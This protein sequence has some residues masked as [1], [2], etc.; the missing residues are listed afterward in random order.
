MATFFGSIFGDSITPDDVSVFVERTPL[1]ST[2]T[3]AND[4]LLGNGGNDTLNGGGGNDF[5]SGDADNDTISDSLGDNELT[6]GAGNDTLSAGTG[7]DTLFGNA[8]DD[9][10]SDTGGA[11]LLNGGSGA[12]TLF[13]TSGADTLLGGDGNDLLTDTG[14]LN[15]LR[16][17]AGN[18]TLNGGI[19][20]DVLDGG[21]GDDLMRGDDGSDFYEVD[22]AADQCVEFFADALA[23]RDTVQAG[24][25]YTLGFG[26]E[27]LFLTDK[28][29]D[30]SSGTGNDLDNFIRG[31]DLRN[32]LSG[33]D[34]NDSLVGSNGDDTLFG[35]AGDD[36]LLGGLGADVLIGEAG[37][38]SMSGADGPDQYFVDSAA[39]LSLE[40]ADTAAAGDDIVWSTAASYVIGFG[41]ERLFLT[42]GPNGVAGD[43]AGTGNEKNNVMRGNAGRNALNGAAGNDS[44][45]GGSGDDTLDGG[46][47]DDTLRGEAGIDILR[48]GAGND[49][50]DGGEGGDGFDLN[51][52]TSLIGLTVLGGAGDDGA[53]FASGDVTLDT[54]A[55]FVDVERIDVFFTRVLGTAGNDRLDFSTIITISFGFGG[56][57]LVADGGGGDDFIAGSAVIGAADTLT[58]GDGDDWLSGWLG[59]DSLLGGLGRDTLDGGTGAGEFDQLEGGPGDDLYIM[60]DALEVVREFANGG[61]DRVAS[62]INYTLV[63]HLEELELAALGFAT[64][65]AGNAQDNLLIGNGLNNRLE[66][67]GG[68]DRL[69]GLDGAD[70]LFGFA[71][72]DTLVG[73]GASDTLSG[74]G[75]NDRMEGGAGTDTVSYGGVT[76][77][78]VASLS[79][80]G[81][82]NTLGAGIDEFIEI[83]NLSG[84]N[85]NDTLAGD[86]GG[87][88]LSGSAGVDRLTGLGGVDTLVGGTGTDLFIFQATTESRAGAADLILGDASAAAFEGAGAA[89]GDVIVL[90]GVDADTTLAGFQSFVFGAS[91]GLGRVWATN[92]TDGTGDT[93]IL[94]ETNGLSGAELTIRIRDGSV[95]AAAYTAADFLV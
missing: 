8:D 94:G 86:G 90:A 43:I 89:A 22:S 37:A 23:G 16:G 18:D 21:T 54:T 12:D 15:S 39:D 26:L 92:A 68:S 60:R 19:S 9:S 47:G 46:A 67:L 27:V 57:A 78:V 81:P 73:G 38:D 71:G 31:N 58:G 83:E 95:L 7:N 48:P 20:N 52:R 75:G 82:Q 63:D 36:T 45:D 59:E 10:L 29:G 85:G 64:F 88:R 24:L 35:G 61:R 32:S 44:I 72:N 25:S 41:I 14:G 84:G 33:L 53:D 30:F 74:G 91:G 4:T 1:F 62:F 13:A 56:E 3:A 79:A 51:A 77:G 50:L 66:G 5:L 42:A 34:G 76:A 87:N 65:G 11:N 49:L 2:V 28:A 17:G 80:F 6:G 40:D 55:R 69:E 70:Q 93:L